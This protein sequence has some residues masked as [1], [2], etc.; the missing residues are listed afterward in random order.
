M[1]DDIYTIFINIFLALN[2]SFIIKNVLD[3]VKKYI[4]D[5]TS[6]IQNVNEIQIKIVIENQLNI[7]N[8]N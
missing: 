1:V 3:Q 7:E 6:T 2:T 5:K 8:I 4:N